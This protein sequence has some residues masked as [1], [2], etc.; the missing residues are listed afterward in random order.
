MSRKV[1]LAHHLKSNSVKSQSTQITRLFKRY[2]HTISKSQNFLYRLGIRA[3]HSIY[4]RCRR[5]A[6]KAIV[7]YSPADR[8]RTHSDSCRH[9]L[10]N[11]FP[12]VPMWFD[13]PIKEVLSIRAPTTVLRHYRNQIVSPQ[14]WALFC[15]Y[16]QRGP[17]RDGSPSFP[18][19]PLPQTSSFTRMLGPSRPSDSRELTY[20]SP[21]ALFYVF[22][23]LTFVLLYF[24]QAFWRLI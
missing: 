20:D 6:H 22:N 1:F 21:T 8:N 12:L 5:R 24:F 4:N 10:P 15:E 9:R 11:N 7:L 2:S 18:S 3:H 19:L 17:L 16:S 23:L 13:Y 14:L